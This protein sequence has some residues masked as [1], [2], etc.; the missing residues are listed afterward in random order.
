MSLHVYVFVVVVVVHGL[1]RISHSPPGGQGALRDDLYNVC[2]G[3]N[4]L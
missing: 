3:V 1:S 4:G 2:R